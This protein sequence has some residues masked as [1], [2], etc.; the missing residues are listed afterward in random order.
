MTNVSANLK[1]G[2]AWLW[3][4]RMTNG[5]KEYKRENQRIDERK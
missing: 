2:G 5:S 3:F 4:P 1:K